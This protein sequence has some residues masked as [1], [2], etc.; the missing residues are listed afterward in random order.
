MRNWTKVET[1]NKHFELGDDCL[2]KDKAIAGNTKGGSIV[3]LN[4]SLTGLD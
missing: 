2:T 4:S 3:P 1:N